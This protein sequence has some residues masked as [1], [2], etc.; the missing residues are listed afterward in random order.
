MSVSA[1]VDKINNYFEGFNSNPSWTEQ[2]DKQFDLTRPE[3]GG[4]PDNGDSLSDEEEE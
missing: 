1:Y 2:L 3:N 4:I